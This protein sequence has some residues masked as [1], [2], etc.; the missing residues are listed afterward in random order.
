MRRADLLHIVIVNYRT[1][2]LA[3]DSVASLMQPNMLPEG[4]RVVVVDGA[5]G[6]GSA[7]KLPAAIVSNGWQER[8]DFLALGVN[9][10]FSYGNNRGIEFLAER[11]GKPKYV[12]LLNPD[13][14]ARA[15]SIT[16]LVEFM[17]RHPRCGIAGSQLEDPDGTRQAC[18]FRFPSVIGE[19]ETGIQFGLLTKLLGRWAGVP[20]LA[21]AP[22][23]A[24]WVCGASMIIRDRVID[25]VGS[26]DEGYFLY[27]EEVDLCL[28]ATRAGWECW[29]MPES[30]VVHLVGQATGLGAPGRPKR[31]PAY[32]FESRQRYYIKNHGSFYTAIANCS[33]VAGHV[34]GRVRRAVKREPNF[35]PPYLLRDFVKHALRGI[36]PSGAFRRSATVN[37]Q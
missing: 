20:K 5:S 11:Y 22:A 27:H 7:V 1:A 14:I 31:L 35:D 36:G 19:F 23:L 2:E 18:V 24:D 10:G 15:G 17:E 34:L 28:R 25:D 16:S 32:W 9:G 26:L 3:L 6:D 37:A 12:H 33:W 8:V 30:R 29:Y 4:T 21:E 13:T